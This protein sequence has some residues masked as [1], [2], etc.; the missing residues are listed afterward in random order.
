[1]SKIRIYLFC[2]VLAILSNFSIFSLKA[3]TDEEVLQVANRE[4]PLFLESIPAGKE[5]LFGFT[6]TEEIS[7]TKPGMPFRIYTIPDELLK[8][9]KPALNTL[10]VPADL[11]KVP[12][13]YR[14]GDIRTFITI[15]KVSDE[16]R[17]VSFQGSELAKQL[18]KY[19]P[20][21]KEQYSKIG[22]VQLTDKS[23]F[24]LLVPAD[25]KLHEGRLYPLNSALAKYPAFTKKKKTSFSMQEVVN[26][27]K[28]KKK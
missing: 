10:L 6:N 28:G 21:F 1:M 27:V 11:W 7:F 20:R 26:I 12:I 17:A 19:K 16:L 25:K 23:E 5:R 8:S 4:Y 13:V 14:N 9:G 3:Q 24:L 18:N 2:L 22:I 15:S